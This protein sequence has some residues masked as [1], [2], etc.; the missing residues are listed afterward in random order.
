MIFS[1]HYQWIDAAKNAHFHV[2]SE[3]VNADMKMCS[4]GSITPLNREAWGLGV[5]HSS[6]LLPTQ[7]P[8]TPAAV[9]KLTQDQVKSQKL[10]ICCF[11]SGQEHFQL[12]VSE[13]QETAV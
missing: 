10:I 11:I 12:V 3:S 4:L 5:R 8:G 1:M 7:V 6:H 13:D 9:E 2:W